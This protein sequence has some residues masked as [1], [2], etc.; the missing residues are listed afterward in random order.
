[1][2][3]HQVETEAVD[4]I[5]VYP[6]QNRFYHILTHHRAVAGSLVTASR[7][8]RIRA[9]GLLTIEIAGNGT[10]KVAVRSIESMVIYHIEHYTDACLMQSLHHLLEF[11]DTNLRRIRVSR[12]GTI[13]YIVVLRVISPVIFILIQLGLIH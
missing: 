8:I 4:M 13:G 6:M 10:L 5:L 11:T 2:N 7:S 1:M 3:S 12:I 9:V